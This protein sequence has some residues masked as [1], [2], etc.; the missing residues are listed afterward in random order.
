MPIS[1]THLTILSNTFNVEEVT[2]Q[3]RIDNEKCIKCGTDS[4]DFYNAD[5]S[6]LIFLCS[7]CY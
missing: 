1:S 2:I 6:T 7:D 4:N 5:Y 3:D